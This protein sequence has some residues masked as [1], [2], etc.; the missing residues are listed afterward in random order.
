MSQLVCNRER[1][2]QSIV[3]NNC[4]ALARIAHSAKLGQSK[5]VTFVCCTANVVSC[6]KDSNVVM[7]NCV[8]VPVVVGLLPGT[9]LLESFL[10]AICDAGAGLK[11]G[12]DG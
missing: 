1:R 3:F 10:C 11:I 8:I 2:R 9:K 4:A 5:C 6:E 12:L 7:C